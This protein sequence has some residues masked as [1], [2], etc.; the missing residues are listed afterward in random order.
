MLHISVGKGD[1]V[2]IGENIRLQYARNNGE[3]SLTIGI[4]AP[5]DIKITRSTLYEAEVAAQAASGDP[6]A[7]ALLARL[8][9]E[10]D[11]RR[12]TSTFRKQKR[13]KYLAAT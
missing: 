4:E 13:A 8:E 2:M 7:Q 12:E 6:S 5:R 11:Q 1:C 9:E 3:G 10:H